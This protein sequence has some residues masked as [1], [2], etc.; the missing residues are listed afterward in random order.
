LVNSEIEKGTLIISLDFELFWGVRDKRT[1]SGYGTSLKNVQQ[2]IPRLLESFS[3]YGVKATFATVGLLFAKDKSEIKQYAPKNIPNYIDSNL[4]PYHN[5]FAEV[6]DMGK[7]DPYH[8]ALDLIKL[9]QDQP[10]HEI[11]THT[12]SH[13]YCLEKGQTKTDFED[14]IKAAIAIAEKE[15][16]TIESIVFPRNQFN[17]SYTD[18]LVENGINSFRGNERV[19]FQSYQSEEETTLLKRIFRTANCYFNLS[20][21]HCYSMRE[22]SSS[23]LPFDIPSSMFLRPYQ[24][25]FSFLK[26]LQLRR[27]K[28]SMTHAAKNGLLYHL[29]WHPHNFGANMDKNFEMLKEIFD[30]YKILQD[31]YGFKSATMASVA[32]E[33]KELKGT[34]N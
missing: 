14:D 17:S 5:N 29:W 12:F 32:K 9:I 25:K 2:V 1:I 15:G 24:V 4:S 16:I 11:S 8:F 3:N 23:D 10:Q 6:G 28:R 31:K 7:D 22:L 34:T 26:P 20:G 33:M 30:H 21:H 18:I 19:W 27:I 13:F